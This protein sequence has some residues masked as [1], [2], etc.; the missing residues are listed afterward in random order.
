[1]TQTEKILEHMKVYGSITQVEAY[2]RYAIFRLG[3]RIYDLRRAG[4]GIRSESVKGTNRF[5]ETMHYSR[6][7]LEGGNEDGILSETER[8]PDA[9]ESAE[10]PV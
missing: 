7:R 8:D 3:A 9:D 1:M 4:Y 5:G 6:Y 10:E 2:N